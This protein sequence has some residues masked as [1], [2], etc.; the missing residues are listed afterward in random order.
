MGRQ[1]NFAMDEIDEKLFMAFLKEKGYVVYWKN[2]Q[3]NKPKIIEQ[4]P[5]S[6]LNGWFIVYI[7][8][9][10]FGDMKFNQYVSNKEIKSKKYYI[11]PTT[12]PVIEFMRTIVWHEDKAIR[13]GRIW[14]QMKYW[15]EHGEYVSKSENLD[16]GYKDI[17]KW[18]TK[19]LQ[20]MEQKDERGKIEKN[21]VSR[22][23]VRLF[24]EEGYRWG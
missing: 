1:Y 7:Y 15:N 13:S 9:S 24:E 5:D 10:A 8:H 19:N 4:L 20:K 6:S 11:S 12:A 16:K 14:M 3:H 23:L 18:I 2:D 17:K 21:V 22:E